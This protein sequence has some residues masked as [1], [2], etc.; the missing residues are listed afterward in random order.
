MGGVYA[1]GA[2]GMNVG[3]LYVG[4]GVYAGGGVGVHVGDAVYAGARVDNTRCGGV[5]ERPLI[6][7][8]LDAPSREASHHVASMTSMLTTTARVVLESFRATSKR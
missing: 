4:G 3:E 1:G 8:C 7:A 6:S 5:Y 2:T